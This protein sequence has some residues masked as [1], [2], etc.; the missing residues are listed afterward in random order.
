M[1]HPERTGDV[2]EIRTD[3][4]E[5]VLTALDPDTRLQHRQD[6]PE[7]EDALTDEE[8]ETALNAMFWRAQRYYD[9]KLEPK[10]VAADRLY[11]GE[12]LGNEEE[13][14]SQVVS[15]D[16]SDA[17]RTVLPALMRILFGSERYLEFHP[18]SEQFAAQAAQATDYIAQ[19]VINQDNDGQRIFYVTLK[20]ALTKDSGVLKWWPELEPRPPVEEF[21]GITSPQVQMLQQSGYEILG[22]EQAPTPNPAMPLWN[23]TA[24]RMTREVRARF[25]L[26]PSEELFVDPD[27][28]RL[29]D[30]DYIFHRRTVTVSEMVSRGYGVEELEDYIG[31]GVESAIDSEEQRSRDPQA[32]HLY[33][34]EAMTPDIGSRKIL[35]TEGYVKIDYYGTG[36]RALYKAECVGSGMKVLRLDDWDDPVPPFAHLSGDP[37]PHRW[38]GRTLPDLLDDIQRINSHLLRG[39]LDSL[40]QSLDPGGQVLDG[41]AHLGDLQNKEVGRWV[42][43][44]R[45]GAIQYNPAP[46]VGGDAIQVYQKFRELGEQRTGINRQSGAADASLMQSTTKAGVDSF[47]RSAQAQTELLARMIGEGVRELMMGLYRLV[48]RHQNYART[49]QLRGEW[50]DV[51]PSNWTSDMAVR[52]GVTLGSGLPEDRLAALQ[53]FVGEQKSIIQQLGPSNPISGLPEYRAALAKALELQGVLEIDRYLKPIDPNWTPPPPDPKP[54]PNLII[55]QAE[56]KKAQVAEARL[57]IEQQKV[58]MEDERERDKIAV[59]AYLKGAE[60]EARYKSAVDVEEIRAKVKLNPR[61]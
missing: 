38:D 60:I 19:T 39:T 23:L 22:N 37:E 51:N 44:Y 2:P 12:K 30:A 9:E 41:E 56:A 29:R 34:D 6:F 3:L 32:S 53:A 14:R 10:R 13:G 28:A 1:K 55:A 17:L 24:Q 26:V 33:S 57:G 21:R 42:R 25:D 52:I 47:V 43:V 4:P 46:F 54:D 8:L 20:D 15:R 5:E 59:E 11:R 7:D 16:V 36:E 40:T 27:A 49:V 18:F 31:D 58:V 45:E 61:D 48:R 50:V 35:F